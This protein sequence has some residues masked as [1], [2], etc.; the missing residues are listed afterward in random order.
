MHLRRSPQ[1]YPLIL[2]E[3]YGILEVIFYIYVK[4]EPK[5]GSVNYMLN[6]INL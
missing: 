2:V 1:P 6:Y 4:Y 3:A 5:K